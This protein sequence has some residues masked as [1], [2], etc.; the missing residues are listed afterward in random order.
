MKRRAIDSTRDL[1]PMPIGLKKT[2][3]R[4]NYQWAIEGPNGH[5]I[6]Y[7]TNKADCSGETHCVAFK[8]DEMSV[9]LR[10]WSKADVAAR[11]AAREEACQNGPDHC[12]HY[13]DWPLADGAEPSGDPG[14]GLGVQGICCGCGK[15]QEGAA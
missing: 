3:G 15:A 11:K 4:C 7:C 5:V 6:F 8:D 14:D 13:Q 9:A 2:E 12:D 10:W 1:G